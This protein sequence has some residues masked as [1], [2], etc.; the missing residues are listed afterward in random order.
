MMVAIVAL[1]VGA[2]NRDVGDHPARNERFAHEL[3]H[4]LAS[5]IVVELV[6]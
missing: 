5:A 3:S 6:R 1:A 2:V 4:E